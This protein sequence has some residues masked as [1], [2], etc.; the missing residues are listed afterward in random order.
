VLPTASSGVKPSSGKMA[1]REATTARAT[2]WILDPTGQPKL[3]R[4]KAGLSDGTL[5][6]VQSDELEEG[7]LVITGVASGTTQ[8]A[9]TTN[10][11]T[12]S[13]KRR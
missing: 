10:P 9:T 3:F 7:Q 11:F 4:V 6:E 8:A 13:M 1:S 12:P 5:T 2:I